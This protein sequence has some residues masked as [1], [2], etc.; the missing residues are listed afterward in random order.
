MSTSSGARRSLH[1]KRSRVCFDSEIALHHFVGAP[2][3][4][5]C[6]R[7]LF[8]LWPSVRL[9][10]TAA[11][12]SQPFKTWLFTHIFEHAQKLWQEKRTFVFCF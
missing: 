5:S 4:V 3:A 8:F 2:H 11:T 1:P 12:H 10:E 6:V 7:D 9:R